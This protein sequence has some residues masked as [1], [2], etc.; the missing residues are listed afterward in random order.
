MDFKKADKLLEKYFAGETS[1]SEEKWLQEY[2]SREEN[3]QPGQEYAGELFRY[4][5]QEATLEY[6]EAGRPGTRFGM[7]PI[8]KIAGIAAAILILAG[9]LFFLQKP[10]EPV[11]YAYINGVPVTD[12]ELAIDETQKALLLISEKLSHSTADL[13]YLSKFTDIEK[14]FTKNK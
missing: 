2:F 9:T 6:E 10:D 11:T 7:A 13:L 12:K 1:L 3:A 14:K 4:F 8:I 5:R